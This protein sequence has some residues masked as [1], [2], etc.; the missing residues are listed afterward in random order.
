VPGQHSSDVIEGCADIGDQD[1]FVRGWG[2]SL[3]WIEGLS[4]L[5]V[6]KIVLLE[7]GPE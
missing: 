4:D 5:L 1:G 2:N 6:V 3:Q 7:I